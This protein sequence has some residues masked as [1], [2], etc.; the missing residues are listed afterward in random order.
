MSL[1]A[2]RNTMATQDLNAVVT[3]REALSSAV[4]Y[5]EPRR[6]AYNA[7]L[8]V[9]VGGAFVAGLPVSKRAI[10]AEP[11]LVLFVL[12]VLANVAYCGAYIP[13]VAL[14]LT[15]FRYLWLR[16]RWVVLVIGTLMA[17]A[18]AYLLVAGMFGLVDGNW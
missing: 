7:A 6:L 13:D 4:R 16:L 11:M 1:A 9:V 8:L 3:F 14:Q 2:A 17:C 18:L 10:S 15:S 12:A 5:W